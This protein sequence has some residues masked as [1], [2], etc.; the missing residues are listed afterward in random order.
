VLASGGVAS[1]EDV[2]AVAALG[3]EG[4][5]VGRALYEGRFTLAEAMA[6]GA[7]QRDR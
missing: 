1:L 7:R 2:A 5:I 6:A 3:C 4:V